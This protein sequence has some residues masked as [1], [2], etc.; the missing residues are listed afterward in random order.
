MQPAPKA[1]YHRAIQPQDWTIIKNWG[2]RAAAFEDIAFAEWPYR[3][4]ILREQLAAQHSAVVLFH[5]SVLVGVAY[6]DQVELHGRCSIAQVL[7]APDRRLQ[8]YGRELVAVMRQRA[9]ERYR[10]RE[11]RVSCFSDN[12]SGLLFLRR[13]G[14]EPCDLQAEV[15]S[16]GQVAARIIMK[17]PLI[18]LD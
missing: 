15:L 4:Q 1:C 5:H 17:Q 9:R 3:V 2:E 16:E 13:L 8:G 10:A 11:L 12:V 14:F 6:F 18:A 7:V